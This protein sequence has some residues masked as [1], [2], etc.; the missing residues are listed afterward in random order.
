MQIWLFL[1]LPSSSPGEETSCWTEVT[2]RIESIQSQVPVPMD[3][4]EIYKNRC[5]SEHPQ[6]TA[7][8]K[9]QRN[10]QSSC[11]DKIMIMLIWHSCCCWSAWNKFCFSLLLFV[12]L[13]DDVTWD[14][15]VVC[16]LDWE[17]HTSTC[18]CP[19]F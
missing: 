19:T 15:K 18:I 12:F 7:W 17:C 1:H 6:F 16:E 3:S 2:E 13:L 9:H 5:Y 11:M 8:N 4:I 14:L 10:F